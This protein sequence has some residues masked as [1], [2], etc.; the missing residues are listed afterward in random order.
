MF[1]G[2]HG[3]ILYH[4]YVNSVAVLGLSLTCINKAALWAPS[5][6]SVALRWDSK[7]SGKAEG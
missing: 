2:W 1:H 5:K 6:R 4:H 3:T 7:L